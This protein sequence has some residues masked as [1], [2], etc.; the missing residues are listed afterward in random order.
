MK[1]KLRSLKPEDAPLMLEWMHDPS[2]VE[3]LQTNFAG[4][5][6]D[7]CLA[8]IAAAQENDRDIHLA[9]TRDGDDTYLGTVSLKHIRG[10]QATRRKY[11]ADKT[12][13]LN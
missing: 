6:L 10:G 7:D 5:T 1:V 2:V 8:F 3:K 11:R 9:V 4:K 12:E 13:Q